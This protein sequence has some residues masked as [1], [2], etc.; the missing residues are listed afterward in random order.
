[1]RF[2]PPGAEWFDSYPLLHR[3]C[4]GL[5]PSTISTHSP[6]KILRR[7][8]SAIGRRISENPDIELQYVG[9]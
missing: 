3:Y 2:L 1:M 8:F 7:P 4:T 9:E 6:S 5:S